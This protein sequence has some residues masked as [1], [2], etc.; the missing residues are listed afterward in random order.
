VDLNVRLSARASL[1]LDSRVAIINGIAYGDSL[2][3]DELPVRAGV[4]VTL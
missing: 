3:H 1:Y 4:R 2:M